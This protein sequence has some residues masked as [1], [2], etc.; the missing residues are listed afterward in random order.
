M[1]LSLIKTGKYN[2]EI[3]QDLITLEIK[4]EQKNG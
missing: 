4:S 2:D 1:N 3:I